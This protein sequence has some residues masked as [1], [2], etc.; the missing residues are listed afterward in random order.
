MMA[1]S[2]ES[3]GLGMELTYVNRNMNSGKHGKG[4]I[5]LAYLRKSE[6]LGNYTQTQ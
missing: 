6:I 1:V 3:L 2:S 5:S 4:A